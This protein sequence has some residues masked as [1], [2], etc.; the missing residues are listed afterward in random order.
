M[1]I[2]INTHSPLISYLLSLKTPIFSSQSIRKYLIFGG[3]VDRDT[4]TARFIIGTC[5][6]RNN[7]ATLP[8]EEASCEPSNTTSSYYYEDERRLLDNR[9]VRYY[10][11]L[12]ECFGDF[13]KEWESKTQAAIQFYIQQNKYRIPGWE[14]V[15][16]E[17]A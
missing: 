8:D 10:D 16:K 13:W 7:D 1:I 17:D 12:G 9:F 15:M 4:S 14:L 3:S 6:K 5:R 11:I 2:L